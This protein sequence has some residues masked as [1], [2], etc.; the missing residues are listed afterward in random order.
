MS[1]E[2]WEKDTPK[3]IE[4]KPNYRRN[5]FSED[6]LS[7]KCRLPQNFW[8]KFNWFAIPYICS[9]KEKRTKTNQCGQR[10]IHV[11]TINNKTFNV[12]FLVLLRE[13]NELHRCACKLLH[14][15]TAIHHCATDTM[16]VQYISYVP[17]GKCVLVIKKNDYSA[18]ENTYKSKID[19]PYAVV[20]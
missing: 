6:K 9:K 2:T 11:K 20:C 16:H 17:T 18:T 10:L 1:G 7:V 12:I 4:S 5:V 8:I 13:I 19:W 15:N 3:L 14:T